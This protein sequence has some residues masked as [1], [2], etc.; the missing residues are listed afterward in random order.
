[1]KQSLSEEQ[2]REGI[3]RLLK[4]KLGRRRMIKRILAAGVVLSILCLSLSV[5]VAGESNT[6]KALQFIKLL[7]RAEYY[8]LNGDYDEANRALSEAQEILKEQ[9]EVVEKIKLFFDLS[10]PENTVRSF[11]EAV[12]FG[13]EEKAKACWSKR[14]PVFLVSGMVLMMKEFRREM[15]EED[16]LLASPE[17]L[18]LLLE[19]TIYYEREWTG[20]NSY[21]VWAMSLGEERSKETQYKVIR[22]NDSWKILTIKI[23]E[24]EGIFP[25]KD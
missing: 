19:E 18:K 4:Q 15:V 14:V 13:D 11:F 3:I 16:P 1:M 25:F 20:V 9:R 7:N 5:G 2:I 21:Y 24:E 8:F 23:W 22:E 10:S 12:L 17:M 6:N